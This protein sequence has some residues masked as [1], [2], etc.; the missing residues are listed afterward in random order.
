MVSRATIVDFAQAVAREF[1]PAKIVLFGSHA[2][3]TAGADSDVDLLV[4]LPFKGKGCR[5]AIEIL[6]RVKPPFSL[7]LLVRTPRQLDERM[8]AGD[9]F[10]RRIAEEGIVLYEDPHA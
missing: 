3:G 2:A 5:K 7:D 6:E 1:R 8:K 4:V 9:F 10:L